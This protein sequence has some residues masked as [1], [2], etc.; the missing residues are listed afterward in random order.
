LLNGDFTGA[1]QQNALLIA[2]LPLLVWYLAALVVYAL[3]GKWIRP[4]VNGARLTG[5]VAI[6]VIGF[7][8]ARN[9]PGFEVLGPKPL[10]ADSR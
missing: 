7:G 4:K 1:L 3:K 2:A 10:V 5:V 6:L 8:I 9:L